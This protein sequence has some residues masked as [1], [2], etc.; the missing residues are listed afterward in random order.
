MLQV[1]IE[2]DQDLVTHLGHVAALAESTAL[3][4]GL[5]LEQVRRAKLAAEL[6][7]IGKSAIPA[8]IL[9]KPGPLNDVERSFM[10]RHRRSAS[11]SSPPPQRSR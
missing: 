1:L 7:D 9:D 3:T 8:S 10:E 2:Q 5:P 4:L 6:H 11:G